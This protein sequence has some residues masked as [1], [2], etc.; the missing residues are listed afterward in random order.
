M[1]RN[2]AATLLIR[3]LTA[4]AGTSATGWVGATANDLDGNRY[5]IGSAKVFTSDLANGG[6]S[7]AAATRLDAFIGAIVDGGTAVVGDRGIDL[8][9]QYLGAP[10]EMM[11]GVRR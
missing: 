10:S 3:R 1:Q 4:E 6:L 2:A 5:I 9:Q 8:M 7:V 11:M